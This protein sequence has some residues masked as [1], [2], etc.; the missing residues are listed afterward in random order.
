MSSAPTCP[1]PRAS[2][3]ADFEASV[4]AAAAA[5]GGDMREAVWELLLRNAWLEREVDR[6]A[7]AVSCGYV[8]RH[9]ATKP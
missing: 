2:T 4:E 1:S 5:C 8:R 7:G 3:N 9:P 6:L